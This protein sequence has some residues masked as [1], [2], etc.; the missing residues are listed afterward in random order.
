M[1]SIINQQLLHSKG[2]KKQFAYYLG[3]NN[4]AITFGGAPTSERN[5]WIIML[6]DIRKHT[7]NGAQRGSNSDNGMIGGNVLCLM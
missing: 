7:K 6:I 5:Y 2:E 3:M 1:D 4:G